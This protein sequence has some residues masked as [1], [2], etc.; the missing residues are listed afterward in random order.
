MRFRGHRDFTKKP[1]QINNLPGTNTE[2][3]FANAVFACHCIISDPIRGQAQEPRRLITISR[4]T[5][6]ATTLST[7]QDWV[8]A[9]AQSTQP[10]NVHW[11]DGGNAENARL[12]EMMTGTGDLIAHTICTPG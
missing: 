12:I 5:V 7:L 10:E 11:C 4:D 9:V 3:D 8:D 2:T 6:M 1:M